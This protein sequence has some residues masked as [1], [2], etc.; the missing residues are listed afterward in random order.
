MSEG[1]SP[2]LPVA[3]FVLEGTSE[4]VTCAG[5]WP[6]RGALQARTSVLE[7]GAVAARNGT[8]VWVGPENRLHREV[9]ILP[10]AT[11]IDVRGRAVLPGLSD[12]H[13]HLVWAGDRADEFERRLAGATYSEIA[14][15]GGGILR[16]VDATREASV[17]D[18]AAAAGARMDRLA[19]HGVTS[20]EVKSG[21]GL[22]TGAELRLLEAARRA[23]SARPF[24]VVTTFLGA[25]TVPREARGSEAARARYVDTICDEMIPRVVE[26]G[27][28]RFAD[29]FV[30]G[31]AFS[32][33]EARRVLTTAKRHGLGVKVHADQ[34]AA[35]GA[36]ELAAELGAISA[37]HLEH[38]SERGITWLAEAGT[39]AVL[40]PAATLFLRSREMPPARRMIEAGV[41]IALSTDLNPGSCPCE[42][43]PLVLQLGAL[44]CGLTVD[45][46]IVAGTLNAAAAMGIADRAGSI[47][48]G[49]RCDLL[50]LDAE[51]R[52]Q[53]IYQFGAPRLFMTIA[54][55]RIV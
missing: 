51:H 54:A 22:E 47:E 26:G 42:S 29:A 1:T 23:A 10:G 45:E 46:A 24:E 20:I 35:D 16:T 13:T 25:H 4:L 5:P 38:V 21:Y 28:A 18:L 40:L 33:D 48:S 27:L 12:C 37:E 15:A 52:R 55:G 11:R 39:I 6:A 3:D 2:G 34:L 14:A 43:L 8:I 30:D 36:A 32:L 17:D 7:E 53:F 49:K 44:L 19:R 9:R 50:V 41:P 31:H